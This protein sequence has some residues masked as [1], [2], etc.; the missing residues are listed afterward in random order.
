MDTSDQTLSLD[1]FNHWKVDALRSFLAARG[2]SGSSN[3]RELVALAFAAH[4]MKMPVL[5][6]ALEMEKSKEIAYASLLNIDGTTIPDPISLY[7]K[8]MDEKQGISHWPPMFITDISTFLLSFESRKNAEI[9]LN[10]YKIGKAYEYYAS[11]WIK[12]VFYHP[13]SSTSKYCLLRARCT[14]SQSL[15]AMK[16][17][18]W[19]CCDKVTGS[20]KSAYCSCTSG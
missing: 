9:H 12:E 6:T 7:D 10:Q 17:L 13:I 4:T 16:H 19:V 2:L 18:V 5:P 1:D 8:W 3:R 20:I 11:N 15:A 14:P